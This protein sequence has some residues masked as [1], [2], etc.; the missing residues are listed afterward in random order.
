MERFSCG[1]RVKDC[2]FVCFDL[3]KIA[4]R[5]PYSAWICKKCS[6]QARAAQH[7]SAPQSQPIVAVFAVV[8][9]EHL[10]GGELAAVTP[11]CAHEVEIADVPALA[12][13]R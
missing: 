1:S 11:E 9:L 2:F 13:V 12:A 6:P 5:Q 3:S 4:Q 10:H 7:I 8:V